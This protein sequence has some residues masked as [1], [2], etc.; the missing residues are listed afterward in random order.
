MPRLSKISLLLLL[1]LFSL[2][3]HAQVIKPDKIRSLTVDDGLPQGFITGMVQ[4]KQGFMWLST[5]D[6]LARYDGKEVKVFYHDGTNSNSLSTNV[7]SHL[8]I[9]KENDIWI[10][11]NNGVTDILNPLTEKFTH[12]PKEKEFA[13]LSSEIVQS[14]TI[15]ETNND[16]IYITAFNKKKHKN[17]IRYFSWKNINPETILFPKQEFPVFIN[18]D[19]N[20][21]TFLCTDKNLYELTNNIGLKRMCSLPDELS[22]QLQSTHDASPDGSMLIKNDELLI[23]NLQSVWRYNIQNNH[24]EKIRFPSYIT[25]ASKKLLATPADGDL[26]LGFANKIYRINNN[27]SLSLIWTNE[28]K[29]GDFWMMIDRSNVLWVATNTFGV[30]MIDLNNSGFN[31]IKIKDG[32]FYDA[33]PQWNKISVNNTDINTPKFHDEGYDGRSCY[34]KNGN[35]WISNFLYEKIDGEKVSGNS[36]IKITKQHAFVYNL[37][38][39]PAESNQIISNFTFD[40]QNRCWALFQNGELAQVDFQKKEFLNTLALNDSA[41]NYLTAVG[42]NLWIVY[43]DALLSINPTSKKNVWYK[44][45]VFSNAYLMMEVSDPKQKNILWLTSRGNGLIKFDINT[46]KAKSVTTKQGLPN[47]TI[48]CAVA[49]KDGYLWCSSN[50]GIFRFSPADYSV[51]SFTVKDGLQ[52]NEFNR[53]QFI[54][55]PDNKIAFGGTQGYTIFDPDSINIDSYQ[56]AIALTDVDINNESISKY[57]E[58]KNIA[59]TSV[60][61]MHLSYNENFLTF[62]F[63]GMEYNDPEKLQ[64]RYELAGVD[65]HWINAGV[66]NLANYTNLSPGTYD[67]KLDASNTDGLWSNQIKTIHIV[68]TP[69]W[70]KTWWAYTIY[71]LLFG[72]L[73]YLFVSSSI[74]QIKS[75]NKIALQQKEAEQMRALDELKSRFFSNITHEFRTPLSLIISPV[76]QMQH[77]E[78]V[79]SVI[80]KNLAVVQRNAKQLLRLINQLLD[81]SKIESGNM[82]LSLSRGNLKLFAEE[83]GE[84]FTQQADGKNVDLKL[85]ISIAEQEYLFDADKLGKI[86]YNLL[87]NAI[88]FTPENGNITVNVFVEQNGTSSKLNLLVSDTGIGIEAEKLPF[89]FNR[90]YQIDTSSTRKYEGTGIGLA[91]VKELV[92]LMNGT[93]E[94]KSEAGRGTTFNISV[95]IQKATNEPLPQWNKISLPE[96]VDAK[97][98][99]TETRIETALKNSCPLIL[100]VEDN[101][102]LREFISQGLQKNYRTLT[103]AN[104]QQALHIATEELPEIIISDVMMPEMDGYTLCKEIK[105]NIS[106]DHIA[107]ILLT[108]KAAHDSRMQGLRSGADDYMTKPFSFDELELR[109]HNILERQEK[110][111]LFFKSQ[112]NNATA[113]INVKE[114]ENPFISQLYSILDKH[115]DDTTLTVEKLATKAAVSHRTLNRKLS[116]IIGLSATELIKQYRLKRSIEF[117]KAGQNVSEAA[118]SVGF[119]THSHFS[120]SFKNFFG[121]TPSEYVNTKVE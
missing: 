47:N 72:I 1:L 40:A 11:H 76:D 79:P 24:W 22:S 30:R 37:D 121:V 69:P 29:P 6:G 36:L 103:A 107:V 16:Y 63:A 43:Q 51:L 50:K 101:E 34:D 116:S 26:Y 61:T 115:L 110:L 33:L 23:N 57:K 95:P 92:Q 14:Y 104:G 93:F 32:F 67:L 109:I 44:N 25:T 46:G 20:G 12:L 5:N 82:K 27:E 99:D 45:A 9:D 54:H 2:K 60:D 77:D 21:A 106:T 73:I 4:D 83:C 71:I 85:N 113:S 111:R 39:L 75:K 19:K 74:R 91:L 15:F 98:A 28:L 120:T 48:Y 38:N 18:E 94:V 114:I 68:I 84:S 52:G 31:S 117:L 70:W 78:S 119:E 3:L 49:D 86:L 66:Q 8:S 13:W 35:L 10:Q 7:I 59:A 53:Y 58:W 62:H 100:I 41:A 89:I 42:N 56:P 65:K 96:I 112:L 17:E 102:E 87:S 81:M 105:S 90:F 80:K 55:F 64:Y 108:A 88:K 97:I 118:Y